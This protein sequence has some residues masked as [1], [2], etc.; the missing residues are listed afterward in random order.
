MNATEVYEFMKEN[1]IPYQVARDFDIEKDFYDKGVIRGEDLEHGKYYLGKCRNA[2]VGK[3]NDDK[4]VMEHM[5]YKFGVFTKDNVNYLDNDDNF[6]LFVAI[7]EI[8]EK[9]VPEKYIVK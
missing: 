3:W 7:K 2:Y 4:K 5:R 1:D 8:D 9:D 6:D